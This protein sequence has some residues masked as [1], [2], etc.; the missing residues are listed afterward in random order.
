MLNVWE[1][2]TVHSQSKQQKNHS[3]PPP[4][5]VRKNDCG[6]VGT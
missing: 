6:F 4:K 2:V 5:I 3:E 1:V